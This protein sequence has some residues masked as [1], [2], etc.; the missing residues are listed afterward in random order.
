[1]SLATSYSRHKL[2]TATRWKRKRRTLEDKFF[3]AFSPPVRKSTVSQSLGGTSIGFS[4]RLQLHIIQLFSVL[5]DTKF[6]SFSQSLQFYFGIS[7]QLNSIW[8]H[9]ENPPMK[10]VTSLSLIQITKIFHSKPPSVPESAFSSNFT[11]SFLILSCAEWSV[12]L[13]KVWIPLH[14]SGGGFLTFT[15]SSHFD[16]LSNRL[17]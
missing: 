14:R 7:L 4:L 3:T 15:F 6:S 8:Y 5:T 11:G 12:L 10:S 2:I 13:Q 9:H 1:M 16:H 17:Q